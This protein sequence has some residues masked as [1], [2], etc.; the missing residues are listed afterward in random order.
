MRYAKTL[1][2]GTVLGFGAM[3]AAA[4][5]VTLDFEPFA[6]SQAI[7]SYGGLTFAGATAVH[8][9]PFEINGVPSGQI[10][11]PTG[12]VNGDGA[13]RVP[14]GQ[15]QPVPESV[16]TFASAY[17][18]TFTFSYV[19]YDDLRVR[20]NSG[21]GASTTLFDA[22]EGGSHA[23]CQFASTIDKKACNWVTESISLNNV[24]S[25]AFAQASAS[26]DGLAYV[27]NIKYSPTNAVPE[28]STYLLMA[29]GLLGI[30]FTARK[31]MS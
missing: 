8:N 11:F 30:G 28:P 27:D 17:S 15:T 20:T 31:R 22:T 10:Y 23:A 3:A 5:E 14:V 6:D 7:L 29:L 25:I 1:F 12:T 13:M 18:G 4:L 19:S 26:A 16:L 21:A 2:V 9:V 24:T